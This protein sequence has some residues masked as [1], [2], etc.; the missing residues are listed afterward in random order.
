MEHAELLSRTVDQAGDAIVVIDREGLVRAWNR[1]AEELFGHKGADM[2][3]EP[4]TAM[5]P[6][7][8]RAPHDKGFKAAMDSGHLAS[9]G[10]ARRT[11]ALRP[12]SSTVYVTMTFAVVTDA[13]GQALGSV[14]VARE[15]V[16][17]A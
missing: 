1:K 8:L 10:R 13:E 3:G 17:D 14:A 16:R 5:I 15:W 12:D 6:E 7:R 2:L 11:K 9:D 4:L